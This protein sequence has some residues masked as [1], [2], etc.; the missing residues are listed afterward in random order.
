M[1]ISGSERSNC[2]AL[3]LTD[4]DINPISLEIKIGGSLLQ[5]LN[6]SLEFLFRETFPLGEGDDELIR[7]LQDPG[8]KHVLFLSPEVWFA[9]PIRSFPNW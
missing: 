3:S 1:G 8:A 9:H 4:F 2:P 6:S 5:V 7:L